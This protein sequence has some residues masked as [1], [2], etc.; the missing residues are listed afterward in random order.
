M[1]EASFWDNADAAQE[2]I[3]EYRLL[4][5]QTEGLEHCLENLEEASIALELSSEGDESHCSSWRSSRISSLELTKQAL[6]CPRKGLKLKLFG[7]R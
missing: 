7:S 1:N 5:S 3:E 6:V 2:V 4:R